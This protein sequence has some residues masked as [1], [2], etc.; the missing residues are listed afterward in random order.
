LQLVK[1]NLLFTQV[2]PT[3]YSFLIINSDVT[4]KKIG[5][6]IDILNH[7]YKNTK[8]KLELNPE[9]SQ[10]ENQIWTLQL[11]MVRLRGE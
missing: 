11:G 8:S 10:A 2:V 1:Y 9:S 3:G 7:L 6:S 5:E 4:V